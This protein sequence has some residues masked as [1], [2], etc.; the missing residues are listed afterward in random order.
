MTIL[1]DSQLGICV[2]SFRISTDRPYANS[3]TRITLRTGYAV[4][5]LPAFYVTVCIINW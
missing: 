3:N 5:S 4:H 1:Y 2:F